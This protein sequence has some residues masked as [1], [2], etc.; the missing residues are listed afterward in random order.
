[1]ASSLTIGS[2]RQGIIVHLLSFGSLHRYSGGLAGALIVNREGTM[3][4]RFRESEIQFWADQ[5]QYPRTEAELL[6]LR[7]IIIKEKQLTKD[8]LRLICQWKAPRSAGHVEKSDA[9][10][11]EEVTR[12]ALTSKHE[13]ARVEVLTILDGV[14]WPTSSVILH[15]F[16]TEQYPIVDFRALW[17]VGVEVPTQYTFDFWWRYVEY[18]RSIAMRNKVCMRTLDRAL[19][20]YSKVNQLRNKKLNEN[21]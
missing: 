11:I 10:Y 15:L 12:F 5:Y 8:Q 4:L 1:M 19:W 3:R 16:H 7:S 21:S 2:A 17:S 6:E 14:S 20:Q 13:R 18:C 9:S